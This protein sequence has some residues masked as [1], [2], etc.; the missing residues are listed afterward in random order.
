M[1]EFLYDNVKP[2]YGE[3][4]KAKL[5]Y[6]DTYSFTIFIKNRGNL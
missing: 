1:Y 4:K 3:K 2:K 5:C 6:I